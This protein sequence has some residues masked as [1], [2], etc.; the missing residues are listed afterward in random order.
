MLDNTTI[1][2]TDEL[3]EEDP[4]NTIIYMFNDEDD[5]D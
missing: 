2:Q 1:V 5:Q 4:K 3:E